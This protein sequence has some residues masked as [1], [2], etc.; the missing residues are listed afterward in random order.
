MFLKLQLFFVTP[1]ITCRYTLY[2]IFPIVD[3]I[4][5]LLHQGWTECITWASLWVQELDD[6][7]ILRSGKFLISFLSPNFLILIITLHSSS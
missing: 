7:R 3:S 6:R 1:H 2:C 5:R 4:Q